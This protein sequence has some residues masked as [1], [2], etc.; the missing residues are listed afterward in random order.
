MVDERA[1][2]KILLLFTGV[3][4]NGGIQRFNHTLLTALS[5][6][7]LECDVLSMHDSIQSIGQ[8]DFGPRTTI[9]GFSGSRWQFSK[10]AFRTIV[11]NR[12]D[13]VLIGHINLL[14]FTLLALL[15]KP[16]TKARAV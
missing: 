11:G 5:A 3:F 10:C 6:L 4:A 8:R 1:P 16:F 7:D 9:R 14:V 13:W 15:L 2:P 12:Y